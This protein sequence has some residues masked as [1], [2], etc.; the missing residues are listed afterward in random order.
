MLNTNKSRMRNILGSWKRRERER[1][2][3]WMALLPAAAPTHA[4]PS[5]SSFSRPRYGSALL[6]L[7]FLRQTVCCSGALRISRERDRRVQ[8]TT[9]FQHAAV[10]PLFLLVP[11]GTYVM[12]AEKERDP[13]WRTRKTTTLI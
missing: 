5:S 7:L 3:G 4:G 12:T 11:P 1:E 6:V 8:Q 2:M 9:S 10:D 13:L